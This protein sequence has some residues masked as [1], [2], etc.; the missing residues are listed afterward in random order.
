MPG[1]SSLHQPLTC[2]ACCANSHADVPFHSVDVWNGTCFL[3]SDLQHAGL[4]IHLGH[5]GLPCPQ[6]ADKEEFCGDEINDDSGPGSTGSSGTNCK[7]YTQLG[8]SKGIFDIANAQMPH[9]ITYSYFSI[10][11]FLPAPRIHKQPSP[12]M[13]LIIS[14]LQLWSVKLQP[15]HFIPN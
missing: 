5:Q 1:W 14:T 6:Y 13:F 11:S 15:V 3:P 8:C 2:M 4:V 10:N 7:L 9:L 12:L